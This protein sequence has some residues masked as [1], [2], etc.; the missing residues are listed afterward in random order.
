[1]TK[2]NKKN[3][4]N[5]NKTKQKTK[6][7]QNKNKNKTK[8]KKLQLLQLQYQLNK[9]KKHCNY[10]GFA[11]LRIRAFL[12]YRNKCKPINTLSLSYNWT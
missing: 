8:T 9:P 11:Y 1:M 12:I 2:K 7:K 4:K 10:Y 3:K 5:K 6:T